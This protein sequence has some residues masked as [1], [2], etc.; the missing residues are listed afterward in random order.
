MAAAA[1]SMTTTPSAISMVRRRFPPAGASGPR[2]PGDPAASVP[3]SGGTAVVFPGGPS[4]TAAVGQSVPFGDGGEAHPPGADPDR[5]AGGPAAPAPPALP[6]SSRAGVSTD[7]PAD[8]AG[9]APCVPAPFALAPCGPAPFAL[10]P[11]GPAPLA[12]GATPTSEAPA[13]PSAP[14]TP[15]APAAT[16]APPSPAAPRAPAATDSPPIAPAPPAPAFLGSAAVAAASGAL[17]APGEPAGE[18]G[19]DPLA[20]PDS[21]CRGS[22]G[23]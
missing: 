1:I 17:P 12:P 14:L 22:T 15:L 10:A 23:E 13:D 16:S 5:G 20:T 3:G 4:S 2:E 18:P 6:C 9:P 8:A 21:G 19:G 11:C 7:V